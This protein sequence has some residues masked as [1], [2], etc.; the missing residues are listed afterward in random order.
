MFEPRA[1]ADGAFPSHMLVSVRMQYQSG[2]P[3]LSNRV[4]YVM[5]LGRTAEVWLQRVFYRV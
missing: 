3:A 2:Y 1:R 5:F 4:S